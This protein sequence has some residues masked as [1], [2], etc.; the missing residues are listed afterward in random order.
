MKKIIGFILLLGILCLVGCSKEEAQS[1]AFSVK[2]LKV[3][4]DGCTTR[5]E[6]TAN[7]P[8]S[9]TDTDQFVFINTESGQGNVSVSVTVWRNEEYDDRQ[10]TISIHS[11]DG[12]SS[13]HLSIYQSANIGLEL[14]TPET[15]KAEGGE[16]GMNVSTN[17]EIE[18]VETPEWITY[19]SSRALTGYTYS[20]TAEPNKTGS[21]RKGPI[22]L[23]GKNLTRYVNVEQDSYT[24]EQVRIENL[25]EYTFESSWKRKISVVPEYA[26]FSKLSV[27]CD[28]CCE[29]YIENG[30]VLVIK[31]KGYG[32][33]SFQFT[34]GGN[35]IPG[36]TF[37]YLPE[38]PFSKANV[39]TYLLAD[40]FL[41]WAYYSN[42]VTVQSSNENVVE[43]QEGG[44]AVACGI[45]TATVYT[46]HKKAG[47]SGKQVVTVEPFIAT[48][49]VHHYDSNEEKSSFM[50]K[51]ECHE[52]ASF[53]GYYIEDKDGT[54]L[55]IDGDF[56][57]PSARKIETP[58]FHLP[59]E[60]FYLDV[61]K[62]YTITVGVTIGNKSYQKKLEIRSM[63][64]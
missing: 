12:S 26:D 64:L 53:D 24:P 15:V 45:G 37:E 36:A 7:C 10:C 3:D 30:N 32:K 9:I 11:E 13:D 63:Y 46:E 61:I 40:G 43:I 34:S 57:D 35:T 4:K 21:P 33:H 49:E 60:E 27:S 39:K 8:W 58:F 1:V 47:M 41:D 51:I 28:E 17:D 62:E 38:T 50:I 52:S 48:A 20:F 2:E 56:S 59:V 25:P 31:S 55:Y 23:R 29:G 5:I 18:S 14:S 54:L 19:T 44:K 6:I 22:R 42:E 16:F